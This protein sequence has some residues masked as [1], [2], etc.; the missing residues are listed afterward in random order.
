M[1]YDSDYIREA[2][3]DFDVYLYGDELNNDPEEPELTI[4]L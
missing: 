1:D 2:D 4:H 3:L